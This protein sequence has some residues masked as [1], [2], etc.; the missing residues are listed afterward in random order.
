MKNIF[1]GLLVGF[2]SISFF[3]SFTIKLRS[4]RA[5]ILFLFV[6]NIP[7]LLTYRYILNFIIPIAPKLFNKKINYIVF[8]D[9]NELENIVNCI[10]NYT[11]NAIFLRL[12]FYTSGRR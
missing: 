11:K 4:S 9:K 12:C 3:Y 6:L 1:A 8:S 5:I 10:E 2:F 7:I